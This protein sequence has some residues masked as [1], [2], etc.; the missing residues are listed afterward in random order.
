MERVPLIGRIYSKLRE[1]IINLEYRQGIIIG[2]KELA[3]KYG[4]SKTP[5]RE[6]LNRLCLE[7]Y[8]EKFPNKGYMVKGFTFDDLQGIFQ[9][10]G[11]LE[12]AAVELAI[13]KASDH[14]IKMLR[15]IKKAEDYGSDV[16]VARIYSDLNHSFHISIAHLSKNPYLSE[17]LENVLNQIRRILLMDVRSYD[18]TAL[19]QSHLNII[20]AI[21]RRDAEAARGL[22]KTH[23][24][25]AQIRIYTKQA[26]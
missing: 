18:I 21:E 14:E 20:D 15:N 12:C 13:E 10:R 5:I 23:I 19:T 3:E 4:V 9:Y 16:D 11:I 2:E 25:E 24:N 26:N 7:G 22:M 17:E 1:D 8:I 6:V